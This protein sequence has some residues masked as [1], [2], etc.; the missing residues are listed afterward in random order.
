MST[1]PYELKYEQL[2]SQYNWGKQLD[3]KTTEEMVSYDGIIGQERAVRAM[4][5]G[6]KINV[7]GYNIYLSGPTGTGKTSYA[8]K[9][10]KKL[11]QSEPVPDDWCY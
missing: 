3:F 9:Y 10:V 7:R 1:K 8:E 4:E 5:F 11:A 2:T 6:V